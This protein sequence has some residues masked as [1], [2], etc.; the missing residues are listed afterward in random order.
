MLSLNTWIDM[1]DNQWHARGVT[2]P[3]E[4]SVTPL[5][6]SA[7][8]ADAFAIRMPPE[9]SSDPELLARFMFGQQARWVARLM[10]LRDALVAGF[11]IKTASKMRGTGAQNPEK[12]IGI[13]KIYSKSA[14]EIVLGE[15]DKHLD[16]RVSI[17]RRMQTSSLEQAPYLIVSTV[18]HC[19]NRFGRLYLRLIG[20]FHRLIVRATLSRAA[21]AGWPAAPADA[22]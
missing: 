1:S 20:P 18:V 7:D 9:A 10:R 14:N 2:L 19:H 21:R 12:R 22:A 11:G 8:L 3:P 17:L 16:F 5:R 13:F 15:D 6:Q 4:A